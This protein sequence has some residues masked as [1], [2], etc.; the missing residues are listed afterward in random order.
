V[1]FWKT[2]YEK[3]KNVYFKKMLNLHFM[4]MPVRHQFSAFAPENTPLLLEI[5][6]AIL[7]GSRER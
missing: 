3:R 5:S 1:E 7:T 2:G 4:M 6:Y